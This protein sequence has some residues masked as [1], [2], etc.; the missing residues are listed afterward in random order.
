MRRRRKRR[1]LGVPS[2]ARNP[3]GS[4]RTWAT[5]LSTSARCPTGSPRPVGVI[6]SRRLD[7]T[8]CYSEGFRA[9]AVRTVSFRISCR[10]DAYDGPKPAT[11]LCRI[12]SRSQARGP[13]S[14]KIGGFAPV[15]RHVY[16]LRGG[17]DNERAFAVSASTS[18]PLST[19][20]A[21]SAGDLPASELAGP[22]P[23]KS[24]VLSKLNGGHD[25]LR[26]DGAV[27]FPRHLL[28][29]GTT[30]EVPT[31]ILYPENRHDLNAE[32]RR[33]RPNLSRSVFSAIC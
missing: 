9:Y 23:L 31:H 33:F 4:P 27:E 11:I 26:A 17:Y 22:F 3:V 18:T 15:S 20:P 7:R 16:D 5:W 1:R 30:A 25:A 14:A 24:R 13:L 6:H 28:S 12:H 8:L 2:W 19:E 10:S 29:D 21:I 32:T